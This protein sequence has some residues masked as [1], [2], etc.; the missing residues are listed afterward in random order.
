MQ[1]LG[2]MEDV[3][4]VVITMY[5]PMG[6]EFSL[7]NQ[8][9]AKIWVGKP[10]RVGLFTHTMVTMTCEW[11]VTVTQSSYISIYFKIK[12]Y[13]CS[14]CNTVISLFT[15]HRWFCVLAL[16]WSSSQNT[17]LLTTLSCENGHLLAVRV[18]YIF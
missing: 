14:V 5:V 1:S 18:M 4:R 16:D 13:C 10:K 9:N 11:Q 6:L 17:P 2:G 3:C 12:S 8:M 7:L 15:A